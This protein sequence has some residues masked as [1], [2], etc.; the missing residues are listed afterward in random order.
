MRNFRF[1][2]PTTIGA[3]ITPV[4]F[5]AALVSAD[6]GHGNYAAALVLYPL[7]LL[8]LVL[9]AGVASSDAFM[10]QIIQTIAIVL[11]I[12]LAILQF[13]FYGFVLSYARLR[14]SW[15]L[16][17]GVGIIYLHLFGIALWLVIAG[18]MRLTVG[19]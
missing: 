11:V 17:V 3:L 9:F 10:T 16:R 14:D 6:V 18:V 12:G 13:P 5:F 8:I 19:S 2:I 1:W 4:L 7:S 15:W